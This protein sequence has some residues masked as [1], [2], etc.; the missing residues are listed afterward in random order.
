MEKFNMNYRP[1][2]WKIGNKNFNMRSDRNSAPLMNRK[3][4]RSLC[5]HFKEITEKK[6]SDFCIFKQGEC[7]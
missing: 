6:N 7:R 4:P 2:M 5:Q 1:R 3:L